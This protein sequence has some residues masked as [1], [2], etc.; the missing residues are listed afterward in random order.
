MSYQDIDNL[1]KDQR[2]LMLKR[3]YA[4]EKIHGTSAHISYKDGRVAFFAGGGKHEEF[5]KLFNEE[6]LTQKLNETIEPGK[7]VHVYGESYGGKMQGMSATY[8]NK[9]R[10]IVF[11]VKIGDKWL[12]VPRAEFFAHE[13][14]LE[15]VYYVEIS[16]DLEDIDRERDAPSVQAIR[17]GMEKSTDKFGFCPPVREGIVLRPLEEM[18][19]NNGKRTIAK[20]KRDE[21]RET[22]TPRKIVNADKIKILQEAKAIAEEWVTYE[23]LN[24]ILTSGKVDSIIQ[25]TGKVIQLMLE[26]IIKESKGE[27]VDSPEARKEINRA[28]AL[29]FKEYLKSSLYKNVV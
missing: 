24:H 2:I 16:T 9:P 14:G 19:T 6:F 22:K 23:R 13:L 28:T 25:N 12:S 8:G 26:D 1:Y 10:F 21:L 3:C 5:I 17:N 4:M 11:E 15:F 29:M 7:S 20:H 18:V 27:I